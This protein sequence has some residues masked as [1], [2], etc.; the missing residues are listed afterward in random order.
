MFHLRIDFLVCVLLLAA[1]KLK[2]QK[3]ITT[4]GIQ[5]K[6]ILSSELI[7]TGPQTQQE[8]DI[9]FTIEPRAGYAFGM[10]IRKGFNDQFSLETGINYT[11]R[12]FKLSISE[13]STGFNGS[14]SFKYV[15][16]EIPVLALIYIRLGEN[17]YMN[18]AFGASID[19]LPSDWETIG[20]YY[21]HFSQRKS[22][23]L[24]SLLANVGFEYR[25]YDKGYYYLGLSYHRPFTNITTA[26]VAYT[27]TDIPRLEK[28][29]AFFD[30]LGN[31]LTIDLRYFFHEKPQYKQRIQ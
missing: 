23:L 19:L 4:F 7:N 8:G 30:I 13:D 22:W 10:V 24:P 12:N 29:S 16:Y 2:A 21:Q 26:G 15:I 3:E 9:N 6:P 20:D 1:V 17:T 18:T 27:T 28:E 14:S 11:Q 25:T 5:F 31:Y